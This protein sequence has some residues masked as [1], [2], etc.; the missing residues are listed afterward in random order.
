MNVISLVGKFPKAFQTDQ[1]TT[2]GKE[3]K[4]LIKSPQVRNSY[5]SKGTKHRN[6]LMK[7]LL[8][9]PPLYKKQFSEH[10]SSANYE[11]FENKITS[12]LSS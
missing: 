10:Q 9:F 3:K 4:Y 7:Q 12:A 1:G 5:R 6:N 8:F 2:V 11:C